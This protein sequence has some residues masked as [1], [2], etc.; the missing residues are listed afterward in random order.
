M[1][2]SNNYN[3]DAK[4]FFYLQLD[5]KCTKYTYMSL[6]CVAIETEKHGP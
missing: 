6:S 5:A 4:I 2:G 3:D 1:G